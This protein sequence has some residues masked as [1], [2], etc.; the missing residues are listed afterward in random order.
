MTNTLIKIS[1]DDDGE[2]TGNEDWCLFY[3]SRQG[4]MALCTMEYVGIG[5][6]ICVY[7]TKEVSRGGITCPD[8]L[9]YIKDIKAIKL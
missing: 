8:C 5:E 3:N 4:S 9:D 6:S 1:I 7:E 2:V